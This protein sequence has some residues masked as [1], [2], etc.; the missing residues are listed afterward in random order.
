MLFAKPFAEKGTKHIKTW[1]KK[2]RTN[3]KNNKKKL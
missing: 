3:K 1:T 2:K